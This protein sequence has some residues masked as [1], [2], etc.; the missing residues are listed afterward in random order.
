MKQYLNLMQNVLEHGEEKQNRTGTSTYSVFGRQL[1]FDLRKGFPLLTTKK[2]HWKS[3]VHELLWFISGDTNTKYL[4]DNGVTIWDEWADEAGDLGPV[5][6]AQWR[7]W[8]KDIYTKDWPSIYPGI[9]E[10]REK[11]VDQLQSIITQIKNNP[12]S[13]RHIVSAWNPNYLPEERFSPQDN[14]K[15]GRMAL[16][17]CHMIFQFNVSAEGELDLLMYQRSVDTFLGLPFNIAS[18][19]LLLTMVSLVTYTR[20]RH[21][22]WTG[23][24][25][26]LYSNHIEQAKEQLKRTPRELP[27]LIY[28]PDPI[29]EVRSI[30]AFRYEDFVLADYKPWPPIKAEISI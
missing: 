18:Y 22:V 5:Y 7:R 6:G 17:P 28:V 8:P 30:D 26:H 21:L 10:V 3:I 1:R 4:K 9:G 29:P 11:Y 25:V 14:V 24:D 23:G 27:T 12:N 2:V 20:P 13:R 16:A 15:M 19:A